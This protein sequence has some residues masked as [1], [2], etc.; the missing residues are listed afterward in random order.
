MS[1]GLRRDKTLALLG[2]TRHAF[3]YRPGKGKR[4]RRPSG[5]TT[6]TNKKGTKEIVKDDVLIEEIAA[7]KS[8]PET[9]YGYRAMTAA[10]QLKGY[11]VNKK[12]I[13]RIMDSCHLLHDRIK[14]PARTYVK[15]RRVEPTGPLEVIEIDIKYQWVDQHQR[16]AYVLTILDCFTRKALYWCVAYS[17]RKEQVV[18]AWEHVIVY[19][20]Q[21]FGMKGKRIT[22]EVRNDN[23]SRF[24]AQIVRQYLAENGLLQVFTHPY[25]PQE[26]GH[27]ESFHAILGR[28]LERK[29]GFATLIDLEEHLKHFYANYNQVRLHGS[30]DHLTPVMFWDLWEKGYIIRI[31]GKKG[32]SYKLK[33]P[34]YLLLGN[35]LPEGAFGSPD[36]AKKNTASKKRRHSLQLSV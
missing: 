4:G 25:T 24:A 12:K 11:I 27:I 22:I 32:T 21:P 19:Y 9:D 14:R 20:L 2:I 6:K 5:C 31:E 7:I 18:A 23:D 28:S 17:I 8:E 3:Y 1:L 30:L 15:H 13:Y 29:G 34:H 35:G 10:L 16:Y 33:I 36:R 26:N